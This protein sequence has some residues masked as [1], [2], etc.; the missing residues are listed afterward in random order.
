MLKLHVHG[1]SFIAVAALVALAAMIVSPRL[2]RAGE[3]DKNKATYTQMV[4]EVFNK[5]NLAFFDQVTSPTFV[6]HE[7]MPPGISQD[8]DGCKKFFQAIRTGFPDIHV[9]IDHMV[10]EG[11]LVAAHLT[12]NGTHKGEFMG[13]PAT[14]H[15]VTFDAMDFVRCKD[16]KAIEHWGVTDVETLMQQLQAPAKTDK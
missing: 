4:E 9:T 8:R 6:E 3:A 7:Q 2:A 10:A 5:G 15:Q 14:G 1:R 12:W 11:D 13:V 16:G